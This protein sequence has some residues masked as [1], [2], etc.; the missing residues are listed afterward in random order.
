MSRSQIITIIIYRVKAT[1]DNAN[2]SRVISYDGVKSSLKQIR[3][4]ESAG[5]GDV[6]PQFLKNANESVV[7]LSNLFF[8]KVP[9]MALNLL[10]GL[11]VSCVLSTKNG[12]RE[13]EVQWFFTS[14][15]ADRIQRKPES[16]H[17]LG[18]KQE[19]F[20]E[21]IGCFDNGSLL[22]AIMSSYLMKEKLYVIFILTVLITLYCEKSWY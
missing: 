17:L 21:N 5:Y 12:R 7:N 13:S 8:N 18:R 1:S 19:G 15:L 14:L 20:D 2:L 11:F 22:H 6:F 10:T 9:Q 3:H 4:G 16:K